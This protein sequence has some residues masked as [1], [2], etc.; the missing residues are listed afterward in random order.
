MEWKDIGDAVK[1]Y[2][3]VLGSAIGGPAGGA[4]GGAVSLLLGAFGLGGDATP[5]DVSKLLTD[6]ASILKMKEL[7]QTYQVE[8]GRLALQHDQAYLADRQGA[9]SREVDIVKAT[10]SRDV[11]LYI[12]AW[13]VVVGFFVL[14]G[15]MMW[16]TIP[17]ANIGPVNILFGALTLGFG[18]VLNYFFGS[19]QS[20]DIKTKLMAK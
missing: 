9:R 12:L 13:V 5:D 19:S 8:L 16:A 20:S 10:G 15:I 14:T 7:E 3:P 2:A 17:A 4:V 6:P 1:K 11:N 18:C